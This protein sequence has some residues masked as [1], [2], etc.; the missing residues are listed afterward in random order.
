MKRISGNLATVAA[1]T[2]LSLS[3]AS[4]LQPAPAADTK[5]AGQ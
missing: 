5:A 1:L 3:A 2:V 4:A